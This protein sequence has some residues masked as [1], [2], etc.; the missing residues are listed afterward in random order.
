MSWHRRDVAEGYCGACHAFTGGTVTRPC[1]RCEGSGQV[2]DTD[3][4]EPWTA[5]TSLPPGFLLAVQLGLVGPVD[6]PS[7][8]GKA[9][10]PA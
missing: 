3:D 5:W 9:R 1:T 6:C 2:A 8:H 7:C 4:A 10:V